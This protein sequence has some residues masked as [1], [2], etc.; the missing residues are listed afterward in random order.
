MNYCQLRCPECGEKNAIPLHVLAVGHEVMCAYCG[1]SVYLNHTR[2]S[3]DAEPEWQLE[4]M[5]PL[6]EE[7]R[8]S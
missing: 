4:N 1:A 5:A 7:R 3:A 2:P 8:S 6:D